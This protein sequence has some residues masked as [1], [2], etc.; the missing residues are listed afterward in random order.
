MHHSGFTVWYIYIYSTS[1]SWCSFWQKNFLLPKWYMIKK[2][3]KK[4]HIRA[5]ATKKSISPQGHSAFMWFINPFCF[6]SLWYTC[7]KGTKQTNPLLSKAHHL[8][9]VSFCFCL[10]DVCLFCFILFV[11]LFRFFVFWAV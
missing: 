7:K 10:L 2:K 6:L 11:L 1:Q 3:K 5:K 8:F 4:K 9:C